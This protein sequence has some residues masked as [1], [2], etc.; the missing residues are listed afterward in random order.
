MTELQRRT[1]EYAKR[2]GLLTQAE[3]FYAEQNAV[4]VKNAERYYRE[5]FRGRISSWNLRDHH[6]ADT[7]AALVE[8]LS[9]VRGEPAKVVVWAHNSHLGDARATEM[10]SQGEL[11]VGQLMR[12]RYPGRCRLIGFSTYTGTVTAADEWGSPADRKVV[13]PA[14]P[15][16][17]EELLHQVGSKEF[18]LWF[19]MAPSA[20]ETLR[21]ARLERV[22]GVIYRPQA[23][24]QS[25]CFRA[26]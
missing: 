17:V 5:M 11:N 1:A 8:H 12:E 3:A 26:R 21:A 6:M 15:D 14:L 13:R 9:R 10:G 16:S 25:H 18:L 7:L 23:E 24:R 22:I 20:A 2:D 19:G 4:I